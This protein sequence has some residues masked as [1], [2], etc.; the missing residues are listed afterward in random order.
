MNDPVLIGQKFIGE[1]RSSGINVVDAYFVKRVYR[2]EFDGVVISGIFQL[3]PIIFLISFFI[4]CKKKFSK[5]RIS[6]A[7]K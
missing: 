4:P 7:K 2:D 1:I 6:E 3:L 5:E